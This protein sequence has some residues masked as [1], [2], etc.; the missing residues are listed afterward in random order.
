MITFTQEIRQIKNKLI[1]VAIIASF[2]Y[3][4]P[5][6]I[7]SLSRYYE[8]GWQGIFTYHIIITFV[9]IAL[10]LLRNKLSMEIKIHALSIVFLWLAFL[11]VI[12][13]KNAGAYWF[14]LLVVT[15]ST[16]LLGKWTGIIYLLLYL[17]GFVLIYFG[18]RI[19]FFNHDVD[20]NRYSDNYISWINSGMS[21]AFASLILMYYGNLFY[22][23]FTST[24]ENLVDSRNKLEKTLKD[25]K[26]SDERFRI[27]MD[28]FPYP[29]SIKD[30]NRKYVYANKAII[31]MSNTDD[32]LGKTFNAMFNNENVKIIED[33]DNKVLKEEKYVVFDISGPTGNTRQYFRMIKFPLKSP[34]GEPLI[35]TIALSTTEQKVAEQMLVMSEK[36]YRSLFENSVDGFVLFDEEGEII[37]CNK[38]FAQMIGY[39][40]EEVHLKSLQELIQLKSRTEAENTDE[41]DIREHLKTDGIVQC[42][43]THKNGKRIPAEVSTY[44]LTVN[45]EIF[46]WALIRDI[47]ERRAMEQ[48]L[49]KVMIESEEKER[50]RYAKELHDG[51]GPILSTCMI[52][53]NTLGSI[54][55]DKKREEHIQRGLQLLEEAVQNVREISNNMSPIILHNYGLDQA[56]KAFIDKLGGIK[57][58]EF[59]VNSN[60][61]ERL[62]ELTEITL[63]RTLVELINN[64]VKYAKSSTIKIQINVGEQLLEILY[65]DNGQGFDY[66]EI[67]KTGRGFGLLNLENRILKI[68]GKYDYK[69]APSKGVNVIITIDK[70]RL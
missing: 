67:K 69:S 66:E 23:Y 8:I 70:G 4:T 45:D 51:L 38:S 24:I 44:F 36:K 43:F 59:V 58:I 14:I 68:G 55:D 48:K 54:T 26:Y 57:D 52:Y 64:S 33:V 63:Y 28:R 11:G 17:I 60:L 39:D 40:K 62:S 30:K 35:G 16:L 22:N 15:F 37:D 7:G 12:T 10:F 27:F 41:N 9:V 49:Y 5:M 25:L 65:S 50:E 34:D 21:I 61:S 46:N 19:G 18:Y 20:L 29:M 53:L 1:N 32:M 3:V 42:E 47:T 6:L 31:S 56:I 2:I 13:F